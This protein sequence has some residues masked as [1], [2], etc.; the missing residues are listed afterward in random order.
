MALCI[1]AMTAA[2]IPAVAEIEAQQHLTPWLESGFH[3]ALRHGWPARVLRDDARNDKPVLGYFV[4]MVAGDDEELLT[5]TVA[6]ECVGQG[7]GRQLL[8]TLL[9]DARAR[10]AHRLLLE[11]RQSN[12]RAIR[13]YESVGFT[14]A[15][16]R[17]NYYAIPADP[18]QGR[19]AGR[20]DAVLMACALEGQIT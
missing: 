15:G 2:D 17:K 14:I 10:G 5:I 9:N 3:D 1:E 19:A 11:V 7:Y 4:A 12:D 20:E 13:L 6:P 8:E 18:T 16:M